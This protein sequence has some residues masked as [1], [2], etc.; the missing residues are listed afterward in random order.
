MDNC[1]TKS[2]PQWAAELQSV[3]P[4]DYCELTRR[5]VLS[6]Q[7]PVAVNKLGILD[8]LCPPPPDHLK[9]WMFK[10]DGLVHLRLTPNHYLCIQYAWAL[11]F[12]T[13]ITTNSFMC[14][15][16]GCLDASITA[17]SPF[18]KINTA[19]WQSHVPTPPFVK[20]HMEI[21]PCQQGEDCET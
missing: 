2:Y 5:M 15:P 13:A 12:T 7:W 9:V 10:I 16:A 14:R 19:M 18:H 20:P 1:K 21:T 8:I 11:Q 4:C 17:T 6:W 3:C